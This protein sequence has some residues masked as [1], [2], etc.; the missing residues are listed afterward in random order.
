MRA[1]KV[2]HL[3]AWAEVRVS[4][5]EGLALE[6]AF[7]M[8]SRGLPTTWLAEGGGSLA[9]DVGVSSCSVEAKCNGGRSSAEVWRSMSA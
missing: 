7:L 2:E 3:A 1:E 4:L 5:A 6:L 8:L 9:E